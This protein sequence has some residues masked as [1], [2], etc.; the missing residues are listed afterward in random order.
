MPRPPRLAKWLKRLAA[1]AAISAFSVFGPLAASAETRLTVYTNI[2]PELLGLYAQAFSE[3]NPDI[4]IVWVR[5]SAGPIAARLLAEKDAP[6]ADVIFGLAVSAL[7]PLEKYGILEAYAPQGLDELKPEMY[8]NRPEPFW[9]GTN[10]WGSGIC[11]NTR[12]LAA[13]GLPMPQSLR[14]LTDPVYQGQ[15]VAPSPVSSSTAYTDVATWLLHMG[16]KAGWEFMEKLDDNV[17]MYTHSGCKPAQMVAQGEF[18]LGISAPVCAKPYQ[19]RKAPLV[20]VIPQEGTGWDLE[21][22]ALVKGGKNSAAAKKLLD[23]A[24]S[25]EVARIGAEH[26]YIP[27][28]AD[29]TGPEIDAARNGLLPLEPLKV[30]AMRQIVLE[31]WRK[32]FDA[33]E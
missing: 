25:S 4:T 10:G 29:V 21:A 18:A 27:A 33:G 20:V 5:D 30:A 1:F 9:I 12:V 23:F 22:A 32:R 17:K 8:D 24:T 11:V 13:K 19:A 28:R 2:E 14:D 26:G 7:L 3:K 31:E 6:K 15:I 16:E